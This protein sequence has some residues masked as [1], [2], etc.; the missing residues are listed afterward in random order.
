M[1]S[2]KK[3]GI[4]GLGVIGA[5]IGLAL[6]NSKENI[7]VWGKDTQ[8]ETLQKALQLGAIDDFLTDSRLG[9]C[10]LIIIAT[11]LRAIPKVLKEIR[12]KLKQG[13]LVSD[14]GSV[15]NWVMQVFAEQLPEQVSYIGGHPL[16][17]SEKSGINGAD[18][19]LFQNAAYVIT[20][21]DH[22][23]PEQ[24]KKII[25]LVTMLGGRMVTMTAEKH[26]ELVAKVSHL[27]HIM[28][29]TIMNNIKS[30]PDYL[31]L[32]GG[33]LRDTTRIAASSPE[34]WLD[35]IQLNYHALEIELQHVI[36]N[37]QN[38]RAALAKNDSDKILNSL[39]IASRL[40]G[41]ML[42]TRPGLEDC[43]DIVAIIPDQP[44]IIGSL[45]T[46][47]GE[48]GINIQ[49]I[50]LLGIRDEDEG[51]IRITLKRSDSERACALIKAHGWL[52]WIR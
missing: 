27:P 18:K 2:L 47:L 28:A 15:K 7:L 3:I 35:I 13:T 33:G 48:Q 24:L 38:F 11:P 30:T 52:A 25:W 46:L 1:P 20:P 22:I 51:T 44:G 4:I 8:T 14:V 16:A 10:E 26:D 45:G 5:S 12:D 32:A 17:G 23:A 40:R 50:S 19:F 9:E 39:A 34:L 36:N 41:S 42:Q 43:Q 37:L 21:P 29:M 31:N 49:D 6:R